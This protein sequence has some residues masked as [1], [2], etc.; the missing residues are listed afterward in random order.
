MVLTE[1]QMREILDYLQ[2]SC[3]DLN[4]AM[5]D[6]FELDDYDIENEKEL[7][8]YVENWIFLCNSCGWWCEMC[9]ETATGQ[10]EADFGCKDCYPEDD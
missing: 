3:K 9:E 5:R 7:W 10:G 4:D 1:D 2:G 6:L 8:H